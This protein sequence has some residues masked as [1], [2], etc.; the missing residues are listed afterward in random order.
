M[1]AETEASEIILHFD[2]L[3]LYVGARSPGELSDF[4]DRLPFSLYIDSDL[5]VPRL[6]LS[7]Q[8]QAAL[9]KTYAA[10][11]MLSTPTF[12]CS[13]PR[14]TRAHSSITAS[15]GSSSLMLS[16]TTAM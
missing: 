4:P 9:E 8:I 1:R 15:T 10:G 2:E 3:P 16:L 14:L 6:K 7:G 13:M 11:S 5:A 12:A